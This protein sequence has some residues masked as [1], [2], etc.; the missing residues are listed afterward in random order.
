[1]DAGRQWRAALGR[2]VVA[3]ASTREG[4]D[5]GFIDAIKR[6]SALP[7]APLFLLIPR[8]PQR[9]DEAADLLDEAGLPLSGVPRTYRR[10]RT[11]RCCWATAWAKWLSLRGLRCGDRRRQLR[12]VG[13]QNLIEACAAAVPVIVGPH[14]FN[15]QQ[16]AIEAIGPAASRAPTPGRR[17]GRAGIATRRCASPVDGAGRAGVVRD[18]CRCRGAHDGRLVALAGLRAPSPGF[19]RHDIPGS[20][21][22]AV[23]AAARPAGERDRP[24]V[25]FLV[26]AACI[27]ACVFGP[28]ASMPCPSA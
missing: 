17:C 1:M 28:H 20:W 23:S 11:R 14:T 24:G 2:P 16:A 4:E 27:A 9:F 25:Q 19:R 5:A 12:A 21:R 8:H 26:Q 6:A 3:V 22:S 13:R 7:G 18:A 15:F 10:V